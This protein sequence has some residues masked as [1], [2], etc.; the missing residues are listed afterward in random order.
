MATSSPISHDYPNTTQPGASVLNQFRQSN[1]FYLAAL[2]TERKGKE[3][4]SRETH[5]AEP[6]VHTEKGTT[7][8][9]DFIQ[10]TG[11]ATRQW[12]LQGTDRPER[13][14]L[15]MG[16]FER[17]AGGMERRSRGV[18]GSFISFPLLLFFHFVSFL[19]T[20][21]LSCYFPTVDCIR[22]NVPDS[23]WTE[24]ERQKR[25]TSTGLADETPQRQ[26]QD[27]VGPKHVHNYAIALQAACV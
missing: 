13:R 5:T 20:F 6:T 25:R 16:K 22:T 15:G 21:F 18:K 7:I 27:W 12:L 3:L 8:L 14:I 1:T 19:C 24:S 4:E 17:G 23:Q 9:I 2:S 26:R 10:Q 11:V